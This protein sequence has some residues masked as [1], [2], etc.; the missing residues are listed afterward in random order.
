MHICTLQIKK[1]R[2][3]VFRNSF[4]VQKLNSKV[5]LS[6]CDVKKTLF[7]TNVY[8]TVPIAVIYK[9]NI[10]LL[11]S[12]NTGWQR[13][14]IMNYSIATLIICQVEGNH[15]SGFYKSVRA[16]NNYWS[17]TQTSSFK[18]PTSSSNCDK[19][20]RTAGLVVDFFRWNPFCGFGEVVNVN[21]LRTTNDGWW[22][23]QIS[24]LSLWLRFA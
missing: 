8:I 22:V 6:N 24:P 1:V 2:S 20:A 4:S 13:E 7:T 15:P 10:K 23:I 17:C 19:T 16:V 11:N 9:C 3:F 12:C 21:M 5:S 18:V 14:W